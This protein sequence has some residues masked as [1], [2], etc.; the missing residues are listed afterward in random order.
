[1]VVMV[2]AADLV[3]CSHHLQVVAETK[4]ARA[5]ASVVCSPLSLVLAINMVAPV[6][7]SPAFSRPSLAA[8]RVVAVCSAR[9]V[10]TKTAQ[11]AL[12][13]ITAPR[14]K[15]QALP[16]KDTEDTSSLAMVRSSQQASSQATM[17]R[18]LQLTSKGMKCRMLSH[19]SRPTMDLMAIL[20]SSSSRRT[21]MAKEVTDSKDTMVDTSMA[22]VAKV[23]GTRF[24]VNVNMR[25]ESCGR[26]R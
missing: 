2:Q 24:N 12:K 6:E 14:H 5:E 18:T 20:N 13:A 8:D 4:A 23:A 7:V 19:L 10:L 1:M 22:R 16:P 9:A 26:Y 25:H 15:L 21:V 11:A 17:M 3:V